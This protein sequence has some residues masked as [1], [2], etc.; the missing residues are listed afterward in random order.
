MNE[1]HWW[2]KYNN[3]LF[4]LPYKRSD[5]V[6]ALIHGNKRKTSD[7][8]LIYKEGYI[9]T[10]KNN[11]DSYC[12]PENIN[13]DYNFGYLLGAYAAEGCM[14]NNQISISNNDLNYLRPIEEICIRFNLT[15][16]IYKQNNKN[17]ENWTSQDIRI[18][19]TVLCRI[20]E[21]LIGKLSSNK[22]IHESIIFSNDE[23][24]KG[25]LD[26]YICGDGTIHRRKRIMEVI[27]MKIYQ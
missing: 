24:L 15:Y 17:K 5:T 13:L 16:K 10:L 23:C 27:N 12:I 26:A 1:H 22:Y 6:Y 20:F 14:T 3:V 25:F 4:K 9:Y 18:Y 11:I 19:N 8:K 21:K 2:K 7:K